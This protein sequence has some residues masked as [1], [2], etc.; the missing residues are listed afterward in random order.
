M[1]YSL[2][3]AFGPLIVA[4]IETHC[5][6]FLGP[7]LSPLSNLAGHFSKGRG[8][9]QLPEQWASSYGKKTGLVDLLWR[10]L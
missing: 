3:T 7:H 4:E 10:F 6:H 2:N 1:Q 9:S 5:S 8:V